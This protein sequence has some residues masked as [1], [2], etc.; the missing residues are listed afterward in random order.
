MLN[1]IKLGK[2]AHSLHRDIILLCYNIY[3]VSG[4]VS[5]FPVLPT[6]AYQGIIDTDALGSLMLI[7]DIRIKCSENDSSLICLCSHEPVEQQIDTHAYINGLQKASKSELKNRTIDKQS[8]DFK[9]TELW[10]TTPSFAVQEAVVG[11]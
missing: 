4:E 9:R 11:V 5:E 1:V 8:R 2:D 3:R 7:Q 6:G 10:L